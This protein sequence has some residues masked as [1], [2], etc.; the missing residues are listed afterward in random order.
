MKLCYNFFIFYICIERGKMEIKSL[1]VIR[2]TGTEFE[3][4]DGRIYEHFTELVEIPSVEEFQKIYD[5]WVV[6]FKDTFEKK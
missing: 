3:L 1:K 6:K 4:E 2:V 5:D